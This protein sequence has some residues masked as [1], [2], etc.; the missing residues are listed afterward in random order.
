[1]S[2][3]NDALKRASESSRQAPAPQPVIT[4][5]SPP[6]AV[7][8]S[9]R[10]KTPVFALAAI[11]AVVCMVGLCVTALTT[12]WLGPRPTV[13]ATPDP[14][15]YTGP[16]DLIPDRPRPRSNP[17]AVPPIST[18]APPSPIAAPAT[19]PAPVRRPQS[20]LASS[21]EKLAEPAPA[22][23]VHEPEVREPETAAVAPT[24]TVAE[25]PAPAPITADKPALV[26]YTVTAGDTLSS[27]A[28]KCFGKPTDWPK[29]Y[30]LNRHRIADPDRL[31]VGMTLQVPAR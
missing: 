11:V 30:A 29:V 26:N 18:P 19:A 4:P 10:H 3:V 22:P 14:S 1:M 16:I 27:I 8:M 6:R 17:P 7:P 12:D 9:R 15:V 25:P 31:Q 21:L 28:A 5:L 24:P 20:A 2:L 13:A 23:Q